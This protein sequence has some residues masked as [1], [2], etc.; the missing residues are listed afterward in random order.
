MARQ[1]REPRERVAH[2]VP[3]GLERVLEPGAD[4]LVAR[5]AEQPA[6][7]VVGQHDVPMGVERGQPGRRICDERLEEPARR[8]ARIADPAAV[9]RPP[10]SSFD[11]RARALVQRS[12][13]PRQCTWIVGDCCKAHA[14]VLWAPLAA[15]GAPFLQPR[16]PIHERTTEGGMS[17]RSAD[18][19]AQD[20]ELKNSP[21]AWETA[22]DTEAL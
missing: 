13:P 7:S 19:G 6:E 15:N 10:A 12:L 5:L 8:G 21:I 3:A 17:R 22:E 4:H 18:L 2:R 11:R 1:L 9:A 14:I 16:A 20:P